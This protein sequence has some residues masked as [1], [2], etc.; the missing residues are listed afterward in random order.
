M[1]AT[2]KL[3]R[4]GYEKLEREVYKLQEVD[5]PA[6]T[7]RLK[8][9][10]EDNVGN[11]EDLE[12]N[13]TMESKKRLEEKLSQLLEILNQSE[14]I[15]SNDPDVINIGDRVMLLDMEYD[16]E[17]AL[18]LVD[19]VEVSGD[20]RAITVDSPVGK[21]L[22]GKRVD[23]IVKVKVPDGTIQYKV[24]SFEPIS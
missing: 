2:R 12:L 23:D 6:V 21:A 1:A 3:T 7:Q 20:R 24:L 16:E 10:R 17:L 14:I 19:G 4:D 9:I 13:D 8:A 18:D 5:I 15:E 22:M 11:E